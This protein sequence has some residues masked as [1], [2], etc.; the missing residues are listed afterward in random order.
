M[1]IT[2]NKVARNA[3]DYRQNGLSTTFWKMFYTKL[4]T[5]PLNVDI[6]NYTEK[7]L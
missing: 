1:A 4:K 2:R 7:S 5:N 6:K 3:F